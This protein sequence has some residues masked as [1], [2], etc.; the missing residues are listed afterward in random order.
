M[1]M[2]NFNFGKREYVSSRS[3]DKLQFNVNDVKLGQLPGIF[4]M[5][6]HEGAFFKKWS[7]MWKNGPDK[8]YEDEDEGMS[9]EEP[10]VVLESYHLNEADLDRK[11]ISEMYFH[12][13]WLNPLFAD[14]LISE[15]KGG[16]SSKT[17]CGLVRPSG[18]DQIY[19]VVLYETD[20]GTV[21]GWDY[22]VD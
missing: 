11:K 15:V 21:I 16:I 19:I 7:D 6:K 2:G 14:K 9:E 12:N 1:K 5:L 3:A 22:D 4:D 8:I 10:D 17:I 18:S 20:T 13:H